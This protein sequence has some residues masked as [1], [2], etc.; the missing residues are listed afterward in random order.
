MFVIK[1][2]PKRER[3][4]VLNIIGVGRKMM[5][6]LPGRLWNENDEQKNEIW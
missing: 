1:I 6:L 5:L 3:N 2:L 4:I